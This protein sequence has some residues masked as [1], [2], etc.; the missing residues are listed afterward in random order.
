MNEDFIDQLKKQVKQFGN[1]F[2]NTAEIT[3]I[4]EPQVGKS[5][6]LQN[7]ASDGVK[8]MYSNNQTIDYIKIK[9]MSIL[10][11]SLIENS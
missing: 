2:E 11:W 3:I 1:M 5:T 9:N 6:L 7:I 10:S 4:G 8:Q